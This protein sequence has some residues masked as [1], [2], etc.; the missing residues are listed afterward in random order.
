LIHLPE[1]PVMSK[2]AKIAIFSLL[3]LLSSFHGMS[4]LSDQYIIEGYVFDKNGPVPD[5]IV[6]IQATDVWT[7]TDEEG[8]FK[9]AG[10]KSRKAVRLTAWALGYYIS[11]GTLFVPGQQDAILTLISHTDKDNRDYQW[12]RSYHKTED[13]EI[14]GCAEC[15]SRQDTHFPHDL[16]FDEWKQ[17]A[18]SQTAINPRFLTIYTGMDVFGNKSPVTRFAISR[19]Y[20]MIPLPPNPSQPY[21][22]PGYKLDFPGTAGNCAACHLPVAAIDN[23][24]GVDPTS[25]TGAAG[26][27]VSCDFCHK[28]WDVRLNPQSGLPYA[29]MPGVLSFEFRR[30]EK[31]HQF[32]SGPLDDVAPG[33]DAYA[34]FQR[35][36]RFCAPCHFGQF[37]DTIIYNSYGE[38]LESPYSDPESGQTCQD[39]HMPRTG[40][41][42]MARPDKGGLNRDADTIFSHRMP[43]ASDK[44]FLENAVSMKVRA[45]NEEGRI[46]VV[47]KITNDRTGHHIPTDSPL[48]H[49]ILLVRAAD[50]KGK[51]LELSEGGVLPDWIG[52]GDPE[53]GN[54]ASM[55][56][57]VFAKVLEDA[58]T[59][60]S[61]SCSYWLPTR[62]ISDNRIA[63]FATD[64]SEYIFRVRD[65]A[66]V[67]IEVTLLYRR[68]YKELMEQKKWTAPD[69]VI[70][71]KE[72]R[73]SNLVD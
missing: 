69:I 25:V 54:Y 17:D 18:H 15:H 65:G 12:E 6:R 35:E 39:C 32:F 61:P 71:R 20:G 42:Y 28:T 62:I 3:P 31:G 53:K 38:W 47:V 37:W 7:T 8:H 50:E 64:T 57:R 43:G 70:K 21:Y 67:N 33:E 63:A 26:E 44:N 52:R 58:W 27:G 55:P 48:R 72:L 1:K 2:A 29:D 41:S 24:Y 30:P 68:A 16:P 11:G 46:S 19:D 51:T 13:G 40:T 5:A 56:G 23:P 73:I 49:L 36:S 22:G 59:R 60:M 4:P 34:P 66:S 14:K 10:L 9:I 45:E